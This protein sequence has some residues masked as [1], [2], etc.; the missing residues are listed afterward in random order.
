M[1]RLERVENCLSCGSTDLHHLIDSK[2][3]MHGDSEMFTFVLCGS[4]GLVMLN[5]RLP[6]EELAP[7]YQEYYLPFRGPSAWGRYAYLVQMNLA[8]TDRRRLGLAIKAAGLKPE[9]RVLDIGCGK[10]SFLKLL[11][12]RTGAYARGVDFSDEGWRSRPEDYSGLDL[13]VNTIDRISTDRP[14]DLI[15]M[16]H[17][18]EHD[19]HP[20]RTLTHLH[21]LAKKDTTLII[22]VPDYDSW[23]RK[24][25]GSCWE[26]YHTPRHT[27]VYTPATIRE[28]LIRSGWEV[29]QLKRYGTLDSYPLFWMGWKEKM[30]IDWSGSMEKE[31]PGFM[32]GMF[33]AAPL[34]LL[35]RWLPSGIMTLAAR[36]A[37]KR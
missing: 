13:E 19:Y 16:W 3:Q 14:F 5:P 10:P 2:A 6:Q 35:K 34:F 30:G 23:T 37:G 31:F 18:L 7:F 25:Q 29:V 32:A 26:G 28:L 20:R 1:T 15:T 12:R 22:E 24:V 9:S 11:Y 8:R 17:Y 4:C 33:L 27:A 36:P 21:R